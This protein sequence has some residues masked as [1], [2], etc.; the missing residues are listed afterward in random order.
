MKNGASFRSPTANWNAFTEPSRKNASAPGCH[1]PLTMPVEW[2]KSTSRITMRPGCTAPSGTFP[3]WTDLKPETWKSSKSETENWKQ[4][5]SCENIND[6]GAIL[7]SILQE[8]PLYVKTS[9]AKVHF[10]LRW[11]ITG[12]QSVYLLK[13]R[14]RGF[15]F[16]V[17]QGIPTGRQT[18]S[19]CL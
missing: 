19:R 18:C 11:D 10:R 4:P 1:Y 17:H 15:F 3:P 7:K 6:R 5:E 2:S 9:G 13:N 8:Q 12:T 14:N 16:S